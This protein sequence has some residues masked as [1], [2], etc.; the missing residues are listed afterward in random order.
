MKCDHCKWKYPDHFLSQ[1]MVNGHYTKPICG[2][3]ALELL[4][5][6]SNL[7]RDHFQ[8][9]IAESNRKAAIAWRQKHPNDKEE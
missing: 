5:S 3:C 7:K 9:E 4:N 6:T 8:G 2:I 1:M